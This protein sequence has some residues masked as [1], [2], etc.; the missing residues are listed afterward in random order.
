MHNKPS[1][2][3]HQVD[4]DVG[5]AKDERHDPQASG[6]G[7][8]DSTVLIRGESEVATKRTIGQRCRLTNQVSGVV[9]PPQPH[10]AEGAGI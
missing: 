7:L 1:G 2:V 5:I 4:I 9:G 8:I 6:N 10:D 3:M